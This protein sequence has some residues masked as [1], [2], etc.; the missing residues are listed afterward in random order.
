[1]Y[2]TMG[3]RVVKPIL[4]SKAFCGV[5]TLGLSSRFVK[6]LTY[7]SQMNTG[8]QNYAASVTNPQLIP[9][10]RMERQTW[11]RWYAQILNALARD[12]GLLL[13]HRMRMRPW[14]GSWLVSISNTSYLPLLR[15]LLP[16]LLCQLTSTNSYKYCLSILVPQKWV[17]LRLTFPCLEPV[18]LL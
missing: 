8:P 1:L 13:G 16:P 10:S 11:L 6:T 18:A 17:W 3:M 15:F 12:M 5:G 9:Q 2:T 4:V 14:T 7:I